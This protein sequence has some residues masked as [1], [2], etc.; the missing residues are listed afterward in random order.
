MY[1]IYIDTLIC[2]SSMLQVSVYVAHIKTCP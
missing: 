1:Y 2:E